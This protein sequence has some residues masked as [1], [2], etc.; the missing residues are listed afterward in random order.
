MSKRINFYPF[1]IQQ[2]KSKYWNNEIEIS[3]IGTHTKGYNDNQPTLILH[4]PID[5]MPNF[6]RNLMIPYHKYRLRMETDFVMIKAVVA[7]EKVGEVSHD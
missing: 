2:E 7:G 1:I 3:I 5:R 6:I 4:I